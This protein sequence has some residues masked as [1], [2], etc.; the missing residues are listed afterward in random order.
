MLLRNALKLDT[1]AQA[2]EAAIE[3]VLVSG[4][5]TADLAGSGPSVGTKQ[6][7]ASIAAAI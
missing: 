1:Q 4:L 3:K 6:M 5:K 2:V 7:A